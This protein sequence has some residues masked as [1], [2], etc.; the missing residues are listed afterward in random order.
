M[1]R[2]ADRQ[3]GRQTGKGTGRQ[4]GGPRSQKLDLIFDKMIR[5]RTNNRESKDLRS[6]TILLWVV[7]THFVLATPGNI[8]FLCCAIINTD[9]VSMS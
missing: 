1:G 3:T 6:T 7:I 5:I 9:Q 2:Q 8:L 4:V